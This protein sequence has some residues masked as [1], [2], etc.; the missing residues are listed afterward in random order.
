MVFIT[1]IVSFSWAQAPYGIELGMAVEQVN[2]LFQW[3]IYEEGISGVH[4]I[5]PDLLKNKNLN[6]FTGYWDGR[7]VFFDNGIVIGIY[8]QSEVIEADIAG[9]KLLAE[10]NKY[11]SLFRAR[12]GDPVITDTTRSTPAQSYFEG[13]SDKGWKLEAVFPND[14]E[15][16]IVTQ[17]RFGFTIYFTWGEQRWR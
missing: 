7:I 8:T 6:V 13:F 17:G 1:I 12:W 4:N 10:W 11:I 3:P 15:L 14:I 5:Q 2:N 16:R 9:E